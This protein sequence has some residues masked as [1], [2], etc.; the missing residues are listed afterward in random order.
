LFFRRFLKKPT[1]IIST[2]ENVLFSCSVFS[3]HTR[4]DGSVRVGLEQVASF[5]CRLP[6][7]VAGRRAGLFL[8]PS[9]FDGVRTGGTKTFY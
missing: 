1:K 3:D 5:E 9:S 7:T 4:T 6:V 8:F 2:D